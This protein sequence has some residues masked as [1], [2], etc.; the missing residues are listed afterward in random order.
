[1]LYPP[2]TE[3]AGVTAMR[4]CAA[5]AMFICSLIVG[6][7]FLRS[8]R[9]ML[10]VPS[11]TRTNYRGAEVPTGAGVIF[12]PTVLVA[13]V[14]VAMVLSRPFSMLGNRIHSNLSLGAGMQ[15]MLILVLG[16][17][18]VGFID[19]IAGDGSARGFKGHLS[20]ALHGR[21]TTG[22]F[23]AVLG[24]VVA[25]AAT[26]NLVILLHPATPP[27]AYGK[28]FLD[29]AL[30]ALAANLLNLLDLRPGRALKIFFPLLIM[31]ILL[32]G[33][34]TV[35]TFGG[36]VSYVPA[37][38]FV[39]PAISI[40]A[41]ALVLFPGDLKEKFMIGDSGANVLGAVI[42]LGLVLGLS[43]WWRL[44]AFIFLV[45]LTAL[46]ENISFSRVIEGNRMLNW[47]DELGRKRRDTA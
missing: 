42:G 3:V 16:M 24:F 43:F 8:S 22:L 29:A 27:G 41:V 17:C 13:Y 21:F 37:Y 19:D 6:W 28:W 36:R 31:V 1:M 35:L 10:S 39:I 26:A 15:T 45:F 4:F 46:S 11:L 44:G 25:L 18:L 34:Y 9:R 23:K 47:L 33:R 30:I 5:L 2:G 20:E 14:V 12:A 32:T 40:A 7:A 38:L